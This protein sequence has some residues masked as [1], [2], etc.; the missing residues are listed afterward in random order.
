V[1]GLSLAMHGWGKFHDPEMHSQFFEG[2]KHMGMPFEKAPTFF[3]WAATAAELV[4]GILLAVGLLSRVAAF[5]I[6]CT[7][8]TAVFKVHW[9]QGYQ[10]M[11]PAAVYAAVAVAFLLGGPGRISVDAMLFGKKKEIEPPE[12]H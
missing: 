7:M 6:M 3:A 10:A 5:F 8:A 11:E 4:G 1:V 12:E 2:V 9:G